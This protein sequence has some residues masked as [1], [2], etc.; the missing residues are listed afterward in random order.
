MPATFFLLLLLFLFFRAF[1]EFIFTVIN[2]IGIVVSDVI[3][4]IPPEDYS[5]MIIEALSFVKYLARIY[6]GTKVLIRLIECVGATLEK[7]FGRPWYE[8]SPFENAGLGTHDLHRSC[9]H[10]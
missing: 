3:K 6:F 10:P 4:D 2:N 7:T 1:A 8:R 9:K 5:K